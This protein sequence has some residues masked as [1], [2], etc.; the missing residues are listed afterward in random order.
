MQ[1][2]KIKRDQQSTDALCKVQAEL[3]K[4]QTELQRTN[5]RLKNM[6]ELFETKLAC[7]YSRISGPGLTH[8]TVG[9]FIVGV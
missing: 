9:T 4:T 1:D 3:T 2:L 7:A 5:E 6:H 8:V